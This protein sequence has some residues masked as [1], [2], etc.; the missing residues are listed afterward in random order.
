MDGFFG[1]ARF[2][3][4]TYF[5]RLDKIQGRKSGVGSFR[6]DDSGNRMAIFAGFLVGLGYFIE[7]YKDN[8]FDQPDYRLG[9][10]FVVLSFYPFDRLYRPGAGIRADIILESQ[11]KY[12]EIER[13]DGE[14]DNKIVDKIDWKG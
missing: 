6:F 8:E 14:E 1:C 4:G 10:S 3:L 2:G 13:G 5:S 7:G 9:H 12:K 11:G